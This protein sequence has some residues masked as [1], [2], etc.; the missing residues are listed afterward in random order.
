MKKA[1]VAGQSLAM[2]R[3]A[4][5]A[6]RRTGLCLSAGCSTC[7]MAC[8]QPLHDPVSYWSLRQG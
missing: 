5:S 8:R 2:Q 4:S 6:A 7:D 1:N 3:R